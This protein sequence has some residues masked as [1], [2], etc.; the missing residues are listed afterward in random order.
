VIGVS[1]ALMSDRYQETIKAWEDLEVLAV[2]RDDFI[3]HILQDKQLSYYYLTLMAK[4]LVRA[5]EKFL[6]Q[7]YSP[8][9]MKLAAVLLDLYEAFAADGKATIPVQREELAAMAGTAKETIIRTLSEFREEGLV[10]ISG[11]DIVIEDVQ[12]LHDLRY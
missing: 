11:T 1:S 4:S 6:L 3:T 7:A 10:R 9:R 8:V 2:K 5:E 12:L